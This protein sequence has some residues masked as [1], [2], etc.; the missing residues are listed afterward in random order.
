[1]ANRFYLPG[2]WQPGDL[3]P[4]PQPEAQ[5]ALRVLRLASGE[6]IEI[7][8]GAGRAAQAELQVESS[9]KASVRITNSLITDV[10]SQPSIA[11]ALA[12]PKGDRFRWIVEKLTELGVDRIIPMK[13]S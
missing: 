5:H 10:P 9:R 6:Q 1:M 11:V 7:F 2:N 8:D 4:L 3:V 12:P 13:T